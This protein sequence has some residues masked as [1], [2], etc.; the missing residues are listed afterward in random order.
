MSLIK[1]HECGNEISTDAKNCP[2]CG[3]K[4]KR[5]MGRTTKLLFGFLGISIVAGIISASLSEQ[6]RITAE[7]AKT[8]EVR[9]AERVE[10]DANFARSLVATAFAKSLRDAAR[11]PDSLKIESLRVSDDAKTVCSEYR[12]KN[13]FGGMNREFMVVVNGKTSQ[14][15]GAWNKHCR[16]RMHDEL[17]MAQDR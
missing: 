3:A 6:N 5:P 8:P 7:A 15:A 13:G 1:C 4:V 14:Q 12:A 17:I 10:K 2:K 16:G 9:A 11:D